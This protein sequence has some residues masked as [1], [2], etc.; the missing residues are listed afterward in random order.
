MAKKI[1]IYRWGSVSEPFLQ[2]AIEK[3]CG[4]GSCMEFTEKIKNYHGDASFAEKFIGV[5][6]ANKIDAVISYDY[7]P[8]ISMICEI[9]KIPYISWIYDCPLYTLQSKTIVNSRN[10][11]FCFDAIYAGRLSQMGAC[12]CYHYPLAGE[13]CF[14]ERVSRREREE[15][16]LK[17]KYQCDI[18]FVGNLYN[19]EKNRIRRAKL[20]DYTS[21]FAE[22]LMLAQ[23][24]VYGYNFLRDSLS[25]ET[26][27]E[28]TRAC[29]LSLGE[30]YYVDLRQMAADALGM[31][32]SAREREQ[33][34]AGLSKSFFVR[35]YTGSKLPDSLCNQNLRKMGHAD[36][37][38]EV[39]LIYH[40][41]KINLNVTS[42]TIESGIPQRVFDILSCR[43]FCLTNYQPEI[44]D[45]FADGEELV[46]Y[47]DGEDLTRKAAYYLEHEEERRRIAENG[48][49]K[50]VEKFSFV[51]RTGQMLDEVLQEGKGR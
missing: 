47:T 11:I 42:K 19:E 17:K 48:Y 41:S 22:G 14:G 27:E 30:E 29:A 31:E 7:F 43:G 4:A 28:I 33:A 12:H 51:E 40:N 34:L 3:L 49:K 1:L 16:E 2:G 9:N 37:E 32:V 13:P 45:C 25:E 24:Q 23:Q 50:I 20:S 6:H 36:Y 18:S 35:L 8:L 26:A 46:I 10:Y 21:G 15:P 39:P 5:L 38:R 44:A